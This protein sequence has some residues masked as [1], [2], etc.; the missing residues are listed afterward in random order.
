[1]KDE[2]PN[3]VTRAELQAELRAMSNRFLIYLGVAVGLIRLDLPAPITVGAV[4]AM[5]AKG[6]VTLFVRH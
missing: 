4:L 3:H 1:M 2:N 5:V 6:A